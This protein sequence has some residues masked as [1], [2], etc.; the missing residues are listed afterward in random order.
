EPAPEER[1][2]RLAFQLDQACLWRGERARARL[3]ERDARNHQRLVADRKPDVRLAV[4]PRHAEARRAA[5]RDPL[6]ERP[7]GDRHVGALAQKAGIAAQPPCARRVHRDLRVAVLDVAV[8]EQAEE[9]QRAHEQ[10]REAG[11]LPAAQRNHAG[12][13]P[14]PMPSTGNAH[15]KQNATRI[16]AH[17]KSRPSPA[18]TMSRRGSRPVAKITVFGGVAIGMANPNDA[19]TVAGSRRTRGSTSAARAVAS[20]TG[21]IS[22]AIATLVAT[23]LSNVT[24]STTRPSARTGSRLRTA[25]ASDRANATL[26]PLASSVCAIANPPASRKNM[27]H[28]IRLAVRQSIKAL[29]SPAPDGMT[30]ASTAMNTAIAPSGTE[31][32]G[33]PTSSTHPGSGPIPPRVIHSSAV[34]PNSASTRRSAGR[35]GPS[36]ASSARSI[37]AAS[38]SV[39][40]GSGNSTRVSSSHTNTATTSDSGANASSHCT[41]ETSGAPSATRPPYTSAP[42]NTRLVGEPIGV[43]I[44]PI[45]DP[46]AMPRRRATANRRAWRASSTPSAC[47]RSTTATPIGISINV[48]AVLLIHIEITA[49]AARNPSTSRRGARP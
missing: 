25:G 28:G 10:E 3:P 46:Y 16:A 47:T 21:I 31:S 26:A 29:P 40:A 41:N 36:A 8:R 12:T 35:I 14:N 43:P 32:R 44:P 9:A 39:R 19:A 24:E 6:G 13:S 18:E 37:A 33:R 5:A 17:A 49:A 7:L 22:D 1:A 11:P 27:S 4:A 48:V 2:E 42:K 45:V 23:S 20:S 38:S 15:A 34:A 30:N